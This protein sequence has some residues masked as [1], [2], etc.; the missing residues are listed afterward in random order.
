MNSF[1]RGRDVFFTAKPAK[2]WPGRWDADFTD[3]K[4]MYNVQCTMYNVQCTG[5]RMGFVQTDDNL[6]LNYE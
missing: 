3:A 1:F 5:S 6:S 4:A 2:V